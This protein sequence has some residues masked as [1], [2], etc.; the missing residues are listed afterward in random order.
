MLSIAA[1]G[2][3]DYHVRLAQEEYYDPQKSGERPGVFIGP[4]AE[5]L[6]L[7]GTVSKEQFKS[8]MRGIHPETKA[9]V[10]KTAGKRTKDAAQDLVFSL[11]KSESV[12][13]G[14]A[15]GPRIHQKFERAFERSLKLSAERVG[16]ATFSRVG[17][18]SRPVPAKPIISCF[19]HT[20]SRSENYD[21]QWHGHLVVKNIGVREDK[22]T[23]AISSRPYYARKM[24]WGALFRCDRAFELQQEFPGI[25]F[26]RTKTGVEIAGVPYPL[27]R[28]FSTRRRQIEAEVGDP[29]NAT[30]IDKAKACLKTRNP[31]QAP[32]PLAELRARWRHDA[33]QFGFGQREIAELLQKRSPQ[34]VDKPKVLQ[35]AF[36]TA[37]AQ[38]TQ[39]HSHFDELAVVRYAADAATGRGVRG[40]DVVDHVARQLRQSPDIEYLGK[41]RGRRRYSTPD[42]LKQEGKLLETAQRMTTR[43]SH[44]I[45]FARL[46][47]RVSLETAA[48]TRRWLTLKTDRTLSSEQREAIDFLARRS[49]Q[50]AILTASAGTARLGTLSRLGEFYLAA[51][52]NVLAAAPS[53][54]AARRLGEETDLPAT[55]LKTLL[56][57]ADRDRSPAVAAK[58]AAKQLVRE[59][60]GRYIGLFPFKRRPLLTRDTVLIIDGAQQIS[61]QDMAKLLGHAKR[62]GFKILL[63]GTPDGLQAIERGIPFA[64]LTRRIPCAKLAE[65]VRPRSRQDARNITYIGSGEAK[66]VLDDLARRGR[67]HVAESH[68]LAAEDLLRKWQQSG[69]IENPEDHLIVVA[70]DQDARQV[71]NR[72]SELRRA[73]QKDIRG[74]TKD[75]SL[76]L[77]SGEK[78]YVGD[79]I[80]CTRNSRR[81]GV[82]RGSPGTLLGVSRRL[83]TIQIELDRGERITLP[84]ATYPYVTRGY[85]QTIWHAT[86]TSHA[87]LL[88]G[89][90]YEDRQAAVVK[91]SRASET[92]HVFIDRD[93]AGPALRDLTRQ[94]SQDRSKTLAT[95]VRREPDSPQQER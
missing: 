82:E 66:A 77:A 52:N 70:S 47:V 51:G 41:V 35:E 49:G 86:P 24:T 83:N 6:G 61:T 68:E 1:L 71:N 38:L 85:A 80:L 54:R 92:T 60:A 13:F 36:D 48:A 20:C 39:R 55:T 25:E 79:R 88:L 62:T 31:K 40:Q 91:F 17:R 73:T 93:T 2:A 44:R 9:A 94:L 84:L 69:G 58:H 10:R 29:D 57:F 27:L 74:V 21:P 18:T 33:R 7:R 12:L 37:I 8:L 28:H 67:L 22:S 50:L 65:V 32:P 4:G 95:D 42:I 72:A 26:R 75:N 34:Q 45:S 23:G 63:A 89:G 43:P 19:I 87:Y 3:T 78:I 11:S 14:V 64:A 76:I 53:G 90:A 46:A 5:L 56:D 59:A 16:E 15:E 81:Y 30:A